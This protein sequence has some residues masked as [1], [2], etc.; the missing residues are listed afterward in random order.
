MRFIM[1]LLSVTASPG[2]AGLAVMSK[3]FFTASLGML[4]VMTLAYLWYTIGS[5]SLAKQLVVVRARS[6]SRSKTSKNKAAGEGRGVT[7]LVRCDVELHEQ[8]DGQQ[9]IAFNQHIITIVV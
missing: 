7:T 3:Y 9:Q 2:L 1:Q 4:I 6:Q 5:A 8:P